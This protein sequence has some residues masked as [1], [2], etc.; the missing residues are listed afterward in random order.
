MGHRVGIIEQAIES[1]GDL[2][3]SIILIN[4]L[5]SVPGDLPEGLQEVSFN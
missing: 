3:I 5:I 1:G 2:I 4:S